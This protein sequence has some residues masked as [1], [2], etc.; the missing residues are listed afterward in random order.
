[1]Q[2]VIEISKILYNTIE[3]MLKFAKIAEGISE[4]SDLLV[5]NAAIEAPEAEAACRSPRIIANEMRRLT[6]AQQAKAT[7]SFCEVMERYNAG[8]NKQ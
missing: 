5:L 8:V 1:L 6:E 7:G 2:N 4:K 3:N